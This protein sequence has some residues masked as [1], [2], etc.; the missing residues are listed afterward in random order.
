MPAASSIDLGAR[1]DVATLTGIGATDGTVLQAG[2]T[3]ATNGPAP[4]VSNLDLLPHR[5]AADLAVVAVGRDGRDGRVRLRND[6]GSVDV[7]L[8]VTG[9]VVGGAP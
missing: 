4:T 1:Q 6:R 9:H 7:A 3:P 8:D 5:A 2:P